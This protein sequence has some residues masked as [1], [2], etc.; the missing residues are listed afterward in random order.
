MNKKECLRYCEKLENEILTGSVQEKNCTE[1]P[2]YTTIIENDFG[3][4]KET[5]FINIED[6]SEEV[7]VEKEFASLYQNDIKLTL[8]S[9]HLYEKWV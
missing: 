1:I 9:K 8:V 6:L 2:T 4:S 3:E 5:D 7:E